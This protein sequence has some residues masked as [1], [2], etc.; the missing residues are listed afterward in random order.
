VKDEISKNSEDFA[1][2]EMKL[3]EAQMAGKR[4]KLKKY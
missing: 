1:S 2:C 4:M 3:R